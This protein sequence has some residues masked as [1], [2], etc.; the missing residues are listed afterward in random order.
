MEISTD[1]G[2]SLQEVFG[3]PSVEITNHLRDNEVYV[4]TVRRREEGAVSMGEK[5]GEGG[6]RG[7]LDGENRV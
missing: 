1:E 4:L 5:E 2:V 6:I 3:Y 7:E